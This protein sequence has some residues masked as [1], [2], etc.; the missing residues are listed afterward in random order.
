MRTLQ[1]TPP[2]MGNPRRTRPN[3]HHKKTVASI[4]TNDN[5]HSRARPRELSVPFEMA[6]KPTC[7]QW[8]Q[9]QTMVKF[10]GAAATKRHRGTIEPENPTLVED[11]AH[12]TPVQEHG[13]LHSQGQ[14]SE[15][16]SMAQQIATLNI[17][18][19]KE[20]LTTDDIDTGS[21]GQ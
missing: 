7:E 20:D 17:G 19:D 14:A 13:S 16:P 1:H 11:T 15:T 21:T 6:P 5:R 8:Q 10:R 18:S 12:N 9:R 3:K 2:K 4:R